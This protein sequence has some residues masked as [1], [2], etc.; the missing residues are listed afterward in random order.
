MA[1][2]L[3]TPMGNAILLYFHER[4]VQDNGNPGLNR[5]NL[6]GRNF[7]LWM[8]IK[9][10]ANTNEDMYIRSVTLDDNLLM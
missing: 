1:T 6:T 3:A 10:I 2:L 7:L 9:I 5:Y 8:A 4:T